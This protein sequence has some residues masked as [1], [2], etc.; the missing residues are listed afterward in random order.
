MT[1]TTSTISDK[2]SYP[3]LPPWTGYGLLRLN[4]NFGRTYIEAEAL[5]RKPADLEYLTVRIT[6][7]GREA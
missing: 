6:K 3:K 7:G 2:R 4:P 5:H 1:V